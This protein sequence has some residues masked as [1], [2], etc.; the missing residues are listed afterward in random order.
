MSI[1]T[2]ITPIILALTALVPRGPLALA[3]LLMWGGQ[4]A[5]LGD[6]GWIVTRGLPTVGAL[7]LLGLL[8]RSLASLGNDVARDGQ[9]A[10]DA[11]RRDGDR[12][13]EPAPA[14]AG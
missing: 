12:D 3:Y 8:L 9:G 7:L 5:A 6:Y 13:R 1:R 4:Q 11:H 2:M 10:D 14:I